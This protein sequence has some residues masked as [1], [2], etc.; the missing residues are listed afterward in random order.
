MDLSE[1]SDGLPAISLME[2]FRVVVAKRSLLSIERPLLADE[3]PLVVSLVSFL[4]DRLVRKG[5]FGRLGA[6]L[7]NEM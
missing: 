3:W 5:G 7:S 6:S 2:D 1:Y 4:G